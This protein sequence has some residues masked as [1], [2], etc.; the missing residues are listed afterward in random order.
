MGGWD[1]PAAAFGEAFRDD[2]F[3][4]DLRAAVHLDGLAFAGEEG[5]FGEEA[6]RHGW[7]EEEEEEEACVGCW[8]DEL[9]RQHGTLKPS[10]LVALSLPVCVV[11]RACV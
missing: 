8:R 2:G 5:G 9:E 7:K 4:G 3:Q 6:E 1:G 11:C 10:L